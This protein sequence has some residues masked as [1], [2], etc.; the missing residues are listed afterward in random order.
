[1]QLFFYCK[2]P[3]TNCYRLYGLDQPANAE[4]EGPPSALYYRSLEASA[5]TVKSLM[6]TLTPSADP[7]A[8]HFQL[9]FREGTI[10]LLRTLLTRGRHEHLGWILLFRG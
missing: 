9:L 1:M 3:Y 2:R 7:M 10:R 5:N 6:V 4:P 8:M